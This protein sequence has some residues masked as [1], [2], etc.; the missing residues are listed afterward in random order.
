[1]PEICLPHTVLNSSVQSS[2]AK[3]TCSSVFITFLSNNYIVLM[4]KSLE[5]AGIELW[6]S[7]S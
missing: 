7:S 4:K 3:V 6:T 2:K 1:M 5:I